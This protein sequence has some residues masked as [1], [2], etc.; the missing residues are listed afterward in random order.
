M[1]LFRRYRMRAR[2]GWLIL[3]LSLAPLVASTQEEFTNMPDTRAAEAIDLML[4]FARRT[5]LDSGRPP[6]R[7]LWTDAFAMCNFL[8]LALETGEKRYKELALRLVDQLHQTLG[9]HRDDDPRSGWISGL[10]EREGEAHPTR[11]GLRIGKS[12][13]ERGVDDLF[14]ERLEWERDGQYFHYLTKWMHALDQVSRATEAPRFNTWAREL[15]ATAHDAFTYLPSAGRAP[16]MYWKMSIDLTRPLVPSMGQHDPLDGYVT[17]MQLRATAAGLPPPAGG[18]DLEDATRRFAAMIE[19]GG[20]ASSDPLGIGGLLVDA[21]RVAQLKRQGGLSDKRLLER[22]LTAALSGLQY[23]AG[24]GELRA[25]AEYRLAFRELGLAIG[26]HAVERMW[27]AAAASRAAASPEVYALLQTLTR[28]TSLGNEIESF[29]R[30][31]EHQRAS[32]WSEHRDINEVML[33]TSLVPK[34]FLVIGRE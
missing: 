34:G 30:N 24:S 6:R 18:P 11:G 14:D 15:A 19:E 32:T 9:R 33:A 8:G 4:G 7:Y 20:W 12:L 25:P 23:Y 22:L 2:F 27:Q 21:Y 1:L 10:S 16:R 26:L 17:A 13:P 3:L 28:Y 5:G 29:W 31:P